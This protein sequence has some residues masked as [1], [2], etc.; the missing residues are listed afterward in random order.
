MTWQTLGP[1]LPK[2]GNLIT[3]CLGRTAL[4]LAGWRVEGEVPDRPKLIVAVAPHSS[5]LDWV[6]SIAVI[7]SLGLGASYLV[8]D[9][10]FRFPLGAPLR[11][12]GAIPV[13]R[14]SAQGLVEQI[15]QRFAG[16]DRLV[17][18]IT[19]EGTRRGAQRWRTG[20]AQVAR[21]ADVPV[22]PTI[23]DYAARVVTFKPL[24]TAVD[25]VDS[26]VSQ[27]R[28]AAASGVP[29]QRRRER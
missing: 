13:H 3:R 27:V 11:L 7:W 28:D 9:T 10:L 1:Q 5:N 29:R 26:V 19:P 4:G 22:L 25:D 8:K 14:G 18:G 17:L 2:A 24:I 15:S 20:F 23:I 6:L 16:Q 12:L 21:V